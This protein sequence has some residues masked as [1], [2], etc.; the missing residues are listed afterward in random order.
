MAAPTAPASSRTPMEGFAEL[1]HRYAAEILG[2]AED[3]D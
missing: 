1:A 2:M 3:G